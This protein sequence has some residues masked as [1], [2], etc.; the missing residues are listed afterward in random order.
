MVCIKNEKTQA[1]VAEEINTK[2]KYVNRIIKKKRECW[3]NDD[4]VIFK[5]ERIDIEKE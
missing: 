5:I 2:K 4:K 3:M 1:Q